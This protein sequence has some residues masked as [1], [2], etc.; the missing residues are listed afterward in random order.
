MYFV[1]VSFDGAAAGI[2]T[3]DA[4]VV[5][6]VS[7]ALVTDAAFVVVAV[8]IIGAGLAVVFAVSAVCLNCFCC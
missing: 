4:V 3:L 8:A 6:V 7:G 5:F 2:G 1:P